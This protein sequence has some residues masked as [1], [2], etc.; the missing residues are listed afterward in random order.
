MSRVSFEST[1]GETPIVVTGGWDHPLQEFFL[2]IERA[3]PSEEEEAEDGVVWSTLE[4]P[5]EDDAHET[6]RLRAKLTEL[7]VEPPPRFW[8][9]VEGRARNHVYVWKQNEWLRH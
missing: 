5:S 7:G 8:E 3:N 2:Q 9:I 6:E 4:D 1:Y